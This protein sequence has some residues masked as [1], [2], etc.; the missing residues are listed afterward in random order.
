MPALSP[1]GETI[2]A[3]ARPEVGQVPVFASPGAPAPAHTLGNPSPEYGALQVFVVRERRDGFVR[4]VLPIRPNASS[5][6]VRESDVT[7]ARHDYRIDVSLS[8]H[9]FRVVRGAQVVVEGGAGIGTSDTPTP[10]GEYYTWVAI[11]PTNSGYGAYAYGL[12]GF[13]EKLSNFNGVDARLGIHGTDDASSIGRDVSHGCIRI[14]NEH[15]TALVEQVG[16]P[17]GVPVVVTA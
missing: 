6:W 17:L 14:S 2:V 4:V 11:D 12:S 16:L 15:V 5:G 7:L 3:T 9:R 8:A 1:A 13:S 10:G